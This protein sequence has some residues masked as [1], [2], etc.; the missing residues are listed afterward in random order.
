M[1]HP[2]RVLLAITRKRSR[3]RLGGSRCTVRPARSHTRRERNVPWRSLRKLHNT[4]P[5]MSARQTCRIRVSAT[6]RLCLPSLLGQWCTNQP[7]FMKPSRSTRSWPNA[8]STTTKCDMSTQS[9]APHIHS[10]WRTNENGPGAERGRVHHEVRQ[11]RQ[12]GR[13]YDHG[14][15][16]NTAAFASKA[17]STCGTKRCATSLDEAGPACPTMGTLRVGCSSKRRAWRLDP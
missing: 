4:S 17:H 14:F 13:A 12:G 7:R 16:V 9:W 1:A 2:H 3:A 6:T 5:T 10:S 8:A 15:N 11:D